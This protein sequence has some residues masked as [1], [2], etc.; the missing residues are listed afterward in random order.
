MGRSVSMGQSVFTLCE[1]DELLNSGGLSRAGLPIE[2]QLMPVHGIVRFKTEPQ[3][4]HRS[5]AIDPAIH[6]LLGF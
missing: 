3:S 2:D 6:R 4:A 1:Q 5:P